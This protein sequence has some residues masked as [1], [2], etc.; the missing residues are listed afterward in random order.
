MITF[1]ETVSFDFEQNLLE[2]QIRAYR[3]LFKFKDG[4]NTLYLIGLAR[5]DLDFCII[6][7]KSDQCK[8]KSFDIYMKGTIQICQWF[9]GK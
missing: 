3:A 9:T 7:T 6:L 2:I 5:S 4:A 1:M 8:D